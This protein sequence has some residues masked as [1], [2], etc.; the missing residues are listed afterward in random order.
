MFSFLNDVASLPQIGI[1]DGQL[2]PYFF[3]Q[4]NSL[5]QKNR[6]KWM[7]AQFVSA[8]VNIARIRLIGAASLPR[9]TQIIASEAKGAP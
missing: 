1:G 5:L 4:E 2:P 6:C 8:T 9:P 3:L 7:A